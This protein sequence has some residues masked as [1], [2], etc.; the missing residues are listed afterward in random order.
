MGHGASRG[1]LASV[2]DPEGRVVELT[3]E[4]WGHVVVAHPELAEFRDEVMDAIRVPYMRAAGRREHEE[5]FLLKKAGPSRW[6]QV[7]VAYERERGWI[8]TAFA[9]R[10]MP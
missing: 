9:R 8:V 3:F 1:I 2:R 4:R 7:V 10:R 5:W 6:L